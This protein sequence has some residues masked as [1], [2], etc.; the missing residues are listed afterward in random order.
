MCWGGN[1]SGQLGNGSLTQSLVP[2]AVGSLAGPASQITAGVDHTCALVSAALTEVE[3]WGDDLRGDLGDGNAKEPPVSMP[4]PVFGF[5]GSLAAG[6]GVV[7]EQVGA[8]N[9]HTCSFVVSGQLYC[10]GANVKGQVGDGTNEDRDVPTLVLGIAAGPQQV[11][12]GDLGG[13]AVTASLSASCWGSDDGS[14]F[15]AHTSAQAVPSLSSGVVALSAGDEGVCRG[16][17]LGDPAMLGPKW[18]WRG[19]QRHH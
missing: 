19:G 10:W 4:E 7:P 13:C 8:G 16:S 18:I 1:A 6:T 14:D 11:T 17:H 9:S 12:E 3:C 5:A 15:A 2:T